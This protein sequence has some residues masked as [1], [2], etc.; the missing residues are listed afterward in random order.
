MVPPRSRARLHRGAHVPRRQA[1]AGVPRL[2]DDARRARAS[3]HGRVRRA[4]LS[5]RARLRAPAAHQRRHPHARRDV[6]PAPRERQPRPHARDGVAAASRARTRAP[7]GA[8]QG[9]GRAPADAA[10]GGRAAH[11]VHHR[12]PD[13]HRRDAGGARRHPA[14]DPRPAPRSRAR[15]GGHRPELPRQADHRAGRRARARRRRSGAHHRRRAAACWTVDVSV[16][17]PPNLSPDDH[18][19]LLRAGPQRLGRHL[20]AHA[21]LREPRGALAARDRA[22][23]HRAGRRATRSPSACRS[24]RATSRAPGGSMPRSG[25]GLHAPRTSAARRLRPS[26]WRLRRHELVRPVGRDRGRRAVRRS[27]RAR[28]RPRHPGGPSAARRRP[29]R[30][31]ALGGRRRDAARRRPATIS[32]PWSARPTPSGPPTSA[33]RSPTSSTATSTSPTSAS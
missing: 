33:T 5:H 13:R 2:P 27:R 21:R 9:A 18:A 6:A 8:R 28:A 23:G 7:V 12:A 26:R 16:Q 1:R 15:A 11:P 17:A 25:H 29:G 4:R 10:R 32:S 22:R 20:A 30:P 24:I 19:L 31:R 3:H 14:R